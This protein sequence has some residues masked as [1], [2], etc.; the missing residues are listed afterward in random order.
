MGFAS[1]Y[2]RGRVNI[3]A[4]AGLVPIASAIVIGLH[5]LRT[6]RIAR[7]CDRF[8]VEYA[9]SGRHKYESF[10]IAWATF[11]RVH[12]RDARIGRRRILAER[13]AGKVRFQHVMND[14]SA[15]LERLLSPGATSARTSVEWP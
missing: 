11:E 9:G 3:A 14:Y 1:L 8:N 12:P 13:A 15:G 6:L 2:T 10:E 5:T 4:L 7:S